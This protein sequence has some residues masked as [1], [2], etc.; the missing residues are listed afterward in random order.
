MV[1]LCP[2]SRNRPLTVDLLIEFLKGYGAL[3]T[4]IA[5]LV[6]NVVALFWLLSN[7]TI[8]FG[9]RRRA[10]IAYL[11]E[12]I[13]LDREASDQRIAELRQDV[14]DLVAER[15]DWRDRAWQAISVGERIAKRDTPPF[16]IRRES[17]P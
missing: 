10:E 13:R 4:V 17:A 11:M 15:D 8:E 9:S 2:Q 3:G 16:G 6:T 5:I 7:G 12:R 14:A 1:S